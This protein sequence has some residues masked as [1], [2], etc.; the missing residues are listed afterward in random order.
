MRIENMH[1]ISLIILRTLNKDIRVGSVKLGTTDGFARD[2]GPVEVLRGTV[3]VNADSSLTYTQVS[4]HRSCIATICHVYRQLLVCIVII[5]L[6]HNISV[7]GT[8]LYLQRIQKQQNYRLFIGE[9]Y[10]G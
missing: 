6:D 7:T 2:V 1:L 4:E 10:I 8:G 5:A 3:H 9:R